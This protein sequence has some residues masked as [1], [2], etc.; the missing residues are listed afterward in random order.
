VFKAT[1]V[2]ALL[3]ASLA[4]AAEE[5]PVRDPMR[6]YGRDTAGGTTAAA[7][8]P[9][10]VL[11]GVV[12][13]PTRRIAIVNGRPYRQ[14]QSVDGAEIVAVEAHAVRLRD[15]GAELVIS[16]RPAAKSRQPNTQGETVP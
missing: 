16:L 10:F 11:T 4:V 15:G 8:A 12:I 6:P 2:C 13:S 3:L 14:G 1:L 7:A 9:R 5:L